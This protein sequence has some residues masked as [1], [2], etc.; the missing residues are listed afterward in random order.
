M[1]LEGV[2][3]PEVWI[4]VAEKTGIEKLRLT[5]RDISDYDELMQMRIGIL[6]QNGLTLQDIQRVIETMEPLPG[7]DEFLNWL[8]SEVVPIILSDTYYE[9]AL[10]LMK[11]LDYPT[12]FCNSIET[13]LDNRITNYHLRIRDGK[14]KAA[15]AF[16]EIGFRVIAMGD[17]YNDTTMLAEAD[18]G[19]LFRPPENVVQEFPQYRVFHDYDEVKAYIQDFLND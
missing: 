4:A 19:I 13:N 8:R 7:A 9:F 14:R 10:P 15:K 16:K 1:D 18:L 2:L 3:V 5:T 17:S 12:L 11:K 6:N